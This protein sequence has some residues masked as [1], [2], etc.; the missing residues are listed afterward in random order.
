MP[1]QSTSSDISSYFRISVLPVS[2]KALNENA[3]PAADNPE[4]QAVGQP[5]S[6]PFSRM[7]L[8]GGQELPDSERRL[9]EAS[10]C[11]VLTARLS[12]VA[13]KHSLRITS[14]HN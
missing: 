9:T 5:P 4:S 3:S 7:T 11:T 2:F 6:N 13:I 8:C 10:H 12:E 1:S 14:R